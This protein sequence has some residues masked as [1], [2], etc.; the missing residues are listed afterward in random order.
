MFMCS[1]RRT[2]IPQ[3]VVMG[4]D[5]SSV[6]GLFTGADEVVIVLPRDGIP[7]GDGG[8][9]ALD[10]L[11]TLLRRERAELEL[12]LGAPVRFADDDP[13]TGPRWL[14]GPAAC[15]PALARYGS[16]HD[17]EV[18]L[19]LDHG[20]QLLVADAP[21]LDGIRET[22]NLLRTLRMTGAETVAASDCATLDEAIAR[23]VTEV[24]DTYPSFK[25]RRLDW[26]AICA[27]HVE[28]VRAAADPLAAMQEW[29][30]ELRDAH[31]WARARPVPVP[32]PYHVWVDR[33]SATATMT[34]VPPGTAAWDA[35]VRPGDTL[36]G[37]DA[38]GWWARTAAPA[39]MRPLL[40]GYRLLSGPVGVAREFMARAAD[41]QMRTW[42][43]APT[44]APAYPLVDWRRLSSGSG[45]LRVEAWRADLHVD[46]A[47]DAAFDELA[48]SERLIVDLRGNVG[49]NATL[50]LSF[51]DRFLRRRAT[52]GSV[53]FSDGTGGLAA[54]ALIVGEPAAPRRR[55]RGAVRFLTDPLTYSA[56]EDALLGLQGLPH[57]GVVGEPSGGGSGRP[58]AVR[59]LPDLMLGVSTALTYDRHGR[60]I[61]GAGIPVDQPVT[62]D[63]FSPDAPDHVLLAA[64]RDW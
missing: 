9:Q 13:G 59:L 28:R 55:W 37:V 41:G 29:L 50:A 6:R 63:R 64:D 19:W 43:D 45:Y 21:D 36:V 12:E 7:L 16:R 5:Q 56:S 20:R 31:T 23:I 54:P 15:N 30:A 42:T 34:R 25:L 26:D 39:H 33:A 35:G 32:L 62:P 40:T 3:G 22:F 49:G 58:R 17:S 51:R 53:R 47:I 1:E 52:L 48:G 44:L 2:S 60:C 46:D 14:I 57:V 38:A 18:G 8:P 61:E 24:D 4:S 27:R 11:G 10:D